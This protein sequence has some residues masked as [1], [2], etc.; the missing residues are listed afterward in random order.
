MGCLW[1]EQSPLQFKEVAYTLGTLPVL[2][3]NDYHIMVPCTQQVHN[4]ILLRGY[5]KYDWYHKHFPVIFDSY[6]FI[7]NPKQL[8]DFMTK[9]ILKLTYYWNTIE[10]YIIVY[11][12]LLCDWNIENL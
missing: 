4:N 6:F 9:N 5:F 7:L 11:L 12:S 10:V 1:T 2:T 3:R 8:V